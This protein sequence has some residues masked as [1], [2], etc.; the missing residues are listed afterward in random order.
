MEVAKGTTFLIAVV[1]I[2]GLITTLIIPTPQLSF[3]SNSYPVSGRIRIAGL[4]L[5]ILIIP[6]VPQKRWYLGRFV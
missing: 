1:M 4:C 3:W 5:I 6:M 2:F